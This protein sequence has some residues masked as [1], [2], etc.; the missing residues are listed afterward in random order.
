VRQLLNQAYTK[1]LV[2]VLEDERI[3]DEEYEFLKELK[4]RLDLSDHEVA[5]IHQSTIHPRYERALTEV[6]ADSRITPEERES[7]ARLETSLRLPEETRKRIY[8]RISQAALQKS[9]EAA[10]SDRRLS[11]EEESDLKAMAE[12]LGVAP[13]MGEGSQALMERYR[14][15]WRVENGDLPVLPVEIR[16]QMGEICHYQAPAQW[17]EMRIAGEEAAKPGIR[18]AKGVR[19]RLEIPMPSVRRSEKLTQVDSGALY[20]T[21][22]RLLFT[23]ES[24]NR[25]IRLNQLPGFE[26]FA[27]A[28]V[29][30]KD[31]G[32]RPYLFLQ[33]DIE[34]AAVVLG[35]VLL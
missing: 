26:V 5:E 3:N 13:S 14:M 24:N 32:R 28:I 9:Y 6:L 12:N 8:H 15:L 7:L 1:A 10:L 31:R 17:W 21:N 18:I 11:P 34:L 33:G 20:I 4:R 29:I 22:K 25:T 16:L 30:D 27:E 23:G 2:Y 19:F 35:A